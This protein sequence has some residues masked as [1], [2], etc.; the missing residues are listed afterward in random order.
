MKAIFQKLLTLDAFSK[1]YESMM[2]L[3]ADLGTFDFPELGIL[4]L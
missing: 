2:A 1:M 3:I 4:A